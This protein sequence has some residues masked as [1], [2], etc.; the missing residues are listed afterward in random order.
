MSSELPA[1]QIA[2]SRATLTGRAAI[3]LLV[4]AV[5]AVSY[6]SSMRAWLTQ[7]SELNSLRQQISEQRVD[8][9]ALQ[10][11]TR[12]WQ[13]PA[14]IETQARLRFGWLMPG[15]TGYRVLG[16]DGEVLSSGGSELSDPTPSAQEPSQ[17]WAEQWDSVVEA[18]QDPSQTADRRHR[19]TRT[20]VDR[21]GGSR[22]A[23]PGG[24]GRVSR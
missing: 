15:E 4:L 16:S 9:A 20:P 1:A 7:R 18:G 3:L 5:L 21:I 8:V 13:D 2:S 11:Q 17:W 24:T 19:P 23:P 6:A 10:Q 12:R 14:Y 22:P